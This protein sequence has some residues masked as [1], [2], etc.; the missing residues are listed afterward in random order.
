MAN[1][2]VVF[3]LSRTSNFLDTS[4]T[5]LITSQLPEAGVKRLVLVAGQYDSAIE[6]DGYNKNSLADTETKLQQRIIKRSQVELEKIIKSKRDIGQ[7]RIA[8]LL[9]QIGDPILSST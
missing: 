9:A 2:D 7:H 6:Q 5:H 8:D 1:S 3:F 4:D